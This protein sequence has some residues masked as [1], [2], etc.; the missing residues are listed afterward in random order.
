MSF[1]G[2]GQREYYLNIASALFRIITAQADD[3][4]LLSP[5]YNA[6][7]QFSKDHA[8]RLTDE[9]KRT[10][11]PS[12]QAKSVGSTE[13]IQRRCSMLKKSTVPFENRRVI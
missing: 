12:A 3:R 13:R 2:Q 6:L 7:M 1:V 11:T 9:I 10:L 4:L 5:R 8:K